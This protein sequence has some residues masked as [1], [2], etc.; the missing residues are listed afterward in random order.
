MKTKQKW[1]TEIV[2]IGI[3]YLDSGLCGKFRVSETVEVWMHKI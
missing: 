3:I 1:L 2:Y